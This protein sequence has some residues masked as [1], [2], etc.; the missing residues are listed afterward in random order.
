MR[1]N[2]K[3]TKFMVINGNAEERLPFSYKSITVN[4][5]SNYLYLGSWVTETGRIGDA[6]KLHKEHNGNLV[7]KFSI[8]CSANTTMPFRVKRAATRSRP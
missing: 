3:K 7:N 1:V 4:N 2:L 6:I 8:F 5:A